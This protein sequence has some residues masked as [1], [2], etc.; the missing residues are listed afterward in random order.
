[1]NNAHCAVCRVDAL[2]ASTPRSECVDA[3]ILWIN[4]DIKLWTK[5]TQI[6]RHTLHA[7][8]H[9]LMKKQV[10]ETQK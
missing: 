9:R 3:K 4:V 5:R 8:K 7:N 1:M 6:E 2:A 10:V